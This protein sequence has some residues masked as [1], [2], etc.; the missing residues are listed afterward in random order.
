MDWMGIPPLA[1]LRAFEAAARN[2]SYSVAARE[3]NVSHAAVAQQV[4]ALESFLGLRLAERAGRGIAPTLEGAMLAE[5]LTRGFGE[6]ADA[7]RELD[8]HKANRPI[9]ITMTPTFAANWFMPHMQSLNAAHPDI[10]L[11]VNPTA[12]VIDFFSAGVDVAVR[13][14]TGN[15]A[16]LESELLMPS[17]FVVIGAP[18]LVGENWQG[19]FEDLFKFHWLQE[20]GTAEVENWMKNQCVEPTSDIRIS[21]MPGFMVL[22]AVQTGQGIATT[23]RAFVADDIA[24]GRL[25]EMYVEEDAGAGY[26]LVTRPGPKRPALKTFLGWLRQAVRD[27]G[28]EGSTD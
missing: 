18:S 6:V 19:S 1:S 7:I 27:T 2:R 14:G 11:S 17:N 15:W 24:A 10:E 22:S 3:L 13:Y 20:Y 12:Q 5:R 21:S 9:H 23:A 8:I 26:Y 4:R 25:V 16:G 28:F